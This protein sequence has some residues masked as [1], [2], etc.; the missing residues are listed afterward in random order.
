[1]TGIDGATILNGEGTP[2]NLL[3]SVGDYYIDTQ[4][5]AL[6]VKNPFG[7]SPLFNIA[8]PTGATGAT[9]ATILN[10]IGK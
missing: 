1:M 6:F 10:G 3:G 4:N 7:W 2:S 8:G 5:S 9:G